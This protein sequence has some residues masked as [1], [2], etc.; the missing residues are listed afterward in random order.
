MKK[1]AGS[2]LLVC[3]VGCQNSPWG[4]WGSREFGQGSIDRQKARAVLTDPYPLNDI[5]P[6]VVGARPREF[7]TPLPEASRNRLQ[8]EVKSR[9]NPW[10]TYPR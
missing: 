2:L 1:I 6:E 8:S 3:L 4:R 5:G 7:S 9:L 10:S